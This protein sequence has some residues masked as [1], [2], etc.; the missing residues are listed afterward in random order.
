MEMSTYIDAAPTSPV[1]VRQSAKAFVTDAGD[2]L[3]VK[4]RHADGRYFWTFPG[5]GLEGDE[6]FRGALRRELGEELLCRA[7]VSDRLTD[8]W[9]AH[10]SWPNT[11]SHC[12]VYRCA[13]DAPVSPN[14]REGIFNH[15]WVR[16][17]DIPAR[18]L[19]PVRY[20]IERELGQP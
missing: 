11:V 7:S 14:P 4:E 13:V 19:F 6:T 8:F 2:V 10:S 12:H 15:R 20:T 17:A 9:Y 5:G 16:P 3:L 1:T 18:T